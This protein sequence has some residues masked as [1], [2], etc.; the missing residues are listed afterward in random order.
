MPAKPISPSLNS[1]GLSKL[2]DI[3]KRFQP[4]KVHHGA[5][6]ILGFW[7]V[8]APSLANEAQDAIENHGKTVSSTANHC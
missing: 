6:D 2:R 3:K 4:D 7:E 8:S 1:N 5:Q